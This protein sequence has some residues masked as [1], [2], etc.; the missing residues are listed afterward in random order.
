MLE[1]VQ[2]LYRTKNTIRPTSSFHFQPQ[3]VQN[4]SLYILSVKYNFET[5]TK[6]VLYTT[7]H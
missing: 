3:N 7:T 2:K 6:T 1:A 4:V 5:D